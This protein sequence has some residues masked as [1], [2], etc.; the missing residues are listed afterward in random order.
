MSKGMKAK[1][2]KEMCRVKL[3]PWIESITD[4]KVK[5]AVTKDCIVTGGAIASMLQGEEVNDYDIYFKTKETALLVAMYYTGIYNKNP[6]ATANVRVLTS[7]SETLRKIERV[8]DKDRVLMF[9]ESD[10][11]AK[12][13]VDAPYQPV[14]LSENA[15]TLSDDIQIIIRFHGSAKEIHENFDFIH[16]TCSYELFEDKLV[17]PPEAL[18][19]LLSKDLQYHGSLFP[20]CSMFRLRKFIQRG[21]S[22][23]GGQMLKIGWQISELDLSNLETLR[24][25]LIGVDTFYFLQL[26]SAIQEAK[27]DDSSFKL[28]AS[29]VGEIIDKIFD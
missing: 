2:I 13:T 22:I 4:P 14:F 11:V 21:W 8:I 3:R 18:E 1:T 27:R 7:E 25:Q 5:Y 10:G 24:D 20:I 28:D 15:I 23:T 19:S 12:A 6:T 26:I 17:L 29:Y 16:A 9:I